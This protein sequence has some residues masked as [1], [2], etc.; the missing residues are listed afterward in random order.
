VGGR[1]RKAKPQLA[2]H[3]FVA[4]LDLVLELLDDG[5][6][7]LHR[8]DEGRARPRSKRLLEPSRRCTDRVEVLGRG[9]SR[10]RAEGSLELERGGLGLLDP[11][12]MLRQAQ[13]QELGS[14]LF[15]LATPGR[16]LRELAQ[17]RHRDRAAHER[18]IA[19]RP[20]VVVQRDPRPAGTGEG[21]EVDAP[22]GLGLCRDHRSKG[23]VRPR[24]RLRGGSDPLEI[25]VQLHPPGSL[26][27][28]AGS[29]FRKRTPDD[30]LISAAEGRLAAFVEAEAARRE[31]E[32]QRTLSVARAETSALLAQEQRKLAEERRD[33]LVRA[34]Q[35]VLTELSGRL[36]AAQKEIEGKLASWAQDLER[37]REGLAT[38]L[39]RLE[40][41][42]RQL[43]SDAESRFTAETERLSSETEDHRVAVVRLRTE[44]E[45]QIKEAVDE[46]A[47]ELETHGAERRRALH[48]VADRLR[49]RERSLA[50]Q[51]DREQTE[52]IRKVTET[53][54]D[55]ERRLVEQVER[56]VARE[57]GRLTEQAAIEFNSA[58]RTTREEAARRLSRE[59]DRSI[60]AFSRQAERLLAERL[61]ELGESG[62]G[63]IERRLQNVTSILER[64]QAEFVDS[65]E[66]RM[67]EVEAAVRERIQNLAGLTGGSPR[68]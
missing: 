18:P 60:E 23:L 43:L 52:S 36:I 34:E 17:R 44:I 51:I 50:E 49:N 7:A 61:A 15:E 24:E 68:G 11:L 3:T 9:Q 53:F 22:S 13:R 4:R 57:A 63:R 28:D 10:R 45:R 30:S 31:A 54:G 5:S 42:Q 29:M 39:T 62:G 33:E 67:S 20:A 58:I 32:L 19:E 56:S 25:R 27:Y 41:R 38:Q 37:V 6:R 21:A 59:L 26:A 46:A 1:S 40:Q 55:V 47:N 2:E 65:L 66:R 48:E 35:R 12:G 16:F 14:Q 8:L 64:R